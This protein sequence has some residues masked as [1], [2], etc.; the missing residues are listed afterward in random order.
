MALLIYHWTLLSSAVQ[1]RSLYATWPP[2]KKK[3]SC[4]FAAFTNWMQRW[5]MRRNCF[6]AMH[7]EKAL[8]IEFS[9]KFTN[10][11][12]KKPMVHY[13]VYLLLLFI[14]KEVA[15]PVKIWIFGVLLFTK[16]KRYLQKRPSKVSKTCPRRLFYKELKK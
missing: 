2:F 4:N 15:F 14:K 5:C 3:N 9:A 8:V 12:I 10:L 16:N 11:K 7:C 1:V 6:E 13:L